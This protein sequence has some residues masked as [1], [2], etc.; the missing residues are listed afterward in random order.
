M[1]NEEKQLLLKDLSARLPYGVKIH[2]KW[3]MF[4][5]EKESEDIGTLLVVDCREDRVLVK[6]KFLTTYFDINRC[7][8]NIKPYLRPME[9]MTEEEEA[10]ATASYNYNKLTYGMDYAITAYV[11]YLYSIHIDCHNLISKGL[12]LPAPEGMYDLKS[13]KEK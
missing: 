5:E 2:C 8:C 12:A 6:R 4:Q 3:H 11:D 7:G 1:T 10:W 13:K 9:S